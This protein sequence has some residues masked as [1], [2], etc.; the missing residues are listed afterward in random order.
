VKFDATLQVDRLGDVP[1]V[2]RAMENIG[3][4][5]V[6]TQETAHDG[7]LPLAIVAEHSRTLEM[8]TAIALAFT[9]SP[10]ALAYTAWDLATSSNGR[11]ILGLGTQVKAHVERRFGMTWDQPLARLREVIL[12]LRAI[13]HSWVTGE[14]LNYSGEFFKFTLMTPFFTPPRWDVA[15]IPI[16]IAGVNTGLCKLAGELCDGFHVH[17]YHSPAYLRDVVR[18]TVQAGAEAAGRSI[19][20]VQFSSTVFVVTG[21]DEE[22][23][24]HSR[25]AARQQ[26][27]F[28][29]S[30]PTYRPVMAHHGWGEVAEN[31]SRLAARK[32]WDEM[33]AL[34]TD[35][36]LETYAV[37]A[38]PD[39]LAGA[40]KARYEGLLD[41]VTYSLPFV[42][43]QRDDLWRMAVETMSE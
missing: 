20:D 1:G 26:I 18:P 15:H 36:M 6:W 12:S 19:D 37:V 10:M 42:P 39:A 3:F 35:E 24:T 21:R 8:G 27:S 22:E 5:G 28:Y 16:Y 34:V 11:F 23:I 25:E 32:Q 41:R 30:T 7:F 9:R 33:P 43:G 29:A 13:W 14:Q 31:L 2:V 4:D 38:P 17:P 40:V